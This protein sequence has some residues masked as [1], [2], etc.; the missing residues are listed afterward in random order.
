[1]WT[2]QNKIFFAVKKRPFAATMAKTKKCYQPLCRRQ[3][4]N[5][6]D[7][8]CISREIWCL[9]Y[10][11]FFPFLHDKGDTIR[12]DWEIQCL[13]YA[14]FLWSFLE[15]LL[16]IGSHFF[17]LFYIVL[18]DLNI[19]YMIFF[20]SIYLSIFFLIFVFYITEFEAIFV[21]WACTQFG[22]SLL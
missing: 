10:V 6:N 3:W 19:L 5:I 22:D 14:G 17:L 1:M 13:S 18:Y 11:R 2:A 12:I 7:T 15:D 9:P 4:K 20:T 21:P 16:L 8:I